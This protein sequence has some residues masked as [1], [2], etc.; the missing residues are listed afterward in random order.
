M[1]NLAPEYAI[2]CAAQLVRADLPLVVEFTSSRVKQRPL[3][4]R[5]GG[6]ELAETRLPVRAVDIDAFPDLRRRF[7]I[8]LLPTFVVLH[9]SAE[10]AR[11]VGPHSRRELAGAIRRALD[12]SMVLVQEP[13]RARARW[14]DF[15]TRL[16]G[17]TSG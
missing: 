5:P 3:A 16:W 12:P 17:F 1:M 15:S 9:D 8:N 6:I 4:S 13:P 7:K 14:N 2:T 11:F 10:L